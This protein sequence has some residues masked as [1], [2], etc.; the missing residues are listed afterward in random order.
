MDLKCIRERC[1]RLKVEHDGAGGTT[2]L[3]DI[4]HGYIVLG[5]TAHWASDEDYPKA[6]CE[7][8]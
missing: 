5:E 2:Y 6:I 7:E 8:D 4:G 3:C 1:K